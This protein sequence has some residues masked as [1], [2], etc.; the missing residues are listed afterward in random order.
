MHVHEGR[1]LDDFIWEVY[2]ERVAR[3]P[4]AEAHCAVFAS[5]GSVGVEIKH[6]SV[7]A[8]I[9]FMGNRLDVVLAVL[10]EAA[11]G[12]RTTV[13]EQARSEPNCTL[14]R[15]GPHQRVKSTDRR[16]AL[17]CHLAQSCAV[18]VAQVA[19]GVVE[20]EARFICA[21]SVLVVADL[22]DR[23]EEIHEVTCGAK[24]FVVGIRIGVS[25]E[26]LAPS[27][28]E[29][30]PFPVGKDPKTVDPSG[31]LCGCFGVVRIEGSLKGSRCL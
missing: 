31:G 21:L 1:M 12:E 28:E 4:A 11:V 25:A 29:E 22:V 8:E 26:K 23:E 3:Q 27:L 30:R 19:H 5:E 15:S 17:F 13:L 7:L 2:V 24:P 14:A 16:D 6:N 20:G 10:D 18:V 9:S